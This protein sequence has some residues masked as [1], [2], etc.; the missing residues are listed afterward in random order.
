[1]AG[2]NQGAATAICRKLVTPSAISAASD[3]LHARLTA[4]TCLS[5]RPCRRTKAFCAPIA[6]IRLRPVRRPVMLTERLITH[7]VPSVAA[8]PA[9][10][11]GGSA[12]SGGTVESTLWPSPCKR[13][14]HE[15]EA[16][17]WQCGSQHD[18][19]TAGR[20]RVRRERLLISP[21]SLRSTP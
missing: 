15:L 17:A 21:P 2:T 7:E 8:A 11:I 14:L 9:V 5:N 10:T 13:S 12:S 6:T 20:K 19:R 3:R 4:K 1:M 18:G 16:Q